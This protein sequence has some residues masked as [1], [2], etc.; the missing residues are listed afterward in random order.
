MSDDDID[1]LAF[2]SI[3]AMVWGSGALFGSGIVWVIILLEAR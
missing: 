2:W 3:L 1:W